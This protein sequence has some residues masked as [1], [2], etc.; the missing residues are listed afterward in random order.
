MIMKW[1]DK[2][3]IKGRPGVGGNRRGM[4]GWSL[5]LG[6]LVKTILGIGIVLLAA[7]IMALLLC[8]AVGSGICK[9]LV[10]AWRHTRSRA[11]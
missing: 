3:P 11:E 2:P 9:G 8:W 6:M 10:R 5:M 4:G 7:P 1:P